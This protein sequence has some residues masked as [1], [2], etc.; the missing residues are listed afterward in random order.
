[1]VEHADGE[2]GAWR[3][4]AED[5]DDD[6]GGGGGSDGLVVDVDGMEVDDVDPLVRGRAVTWR[7]GSHS[8][9][10][11]SRM[12]ALHRSSPVELL[13]AAAADPEPELGETRPSHF[14]LRALQVVQPD[15]IRPSTAWRRRIARSLL[16][17]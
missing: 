9:T 13:P 10:R 1:M 3:L 14:F 8:Q 2:R 12:Q 11:P 17:L 7:S 5:G 4:T 6:D 16:L 15:R